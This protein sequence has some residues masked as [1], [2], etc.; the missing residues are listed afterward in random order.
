[1][2]I[3]AQEDLIT[4]VGDSLVG[5]IVN[6]ESVREVYGNV[7]LKQ[8][9]VT[10]TCN[11]A[12][13][14][15]ARNDAELIG[16]VIAVQENTTIKTE[17]GFYY[18][19]EKSTI[20]ETGVSL[21]DG[22]VIL[23]AVVGEYFFNEDRAFFHKD[24]VLYDT[25]TTLTAD[26]LTYFKSE[27]RT[28]ATGNVRIIDASNIIDSDTLEHFRNTRITFASH[29]VKISNNENN[30]VIYGD[31]LEDYAEKNFT[32][33]DKNPLLIQV[34]TTYNP[35]DS[36]N[37]F[38]LDTLVIQSLVM[39][40][41]RDITNLFYAK[42]S[43][44]IV[45]GDFA[46]TND[47]TI[48]YRDI[49]K[50][51]TSKHPRSLKQPVLWQAN[52]QLTGD[53]VT[54]YLREKQISLMDVDRNAFILSQHDI[55]RDRFDQTSGDRVSIHFKEKT[56]D[57][58]EI[59]G[60]V[61]SIYYL[62]E[63]NEPNGLTKSTSRNAIIKFEDKTVSEVRLYGSPSSE[64]YPEGQVAGKELSFTLPKYV[65]YPD[66]PVKEKLIPEWIYEN[67]G[68]IKLLNQIGIQ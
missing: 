66:R 43:V 7:I 50:I 62:Y 49:D 41:Y 8:G 42:D 14:F 20:S 15:I 38:T 3:F 12:I 13:Q 39:E 56:I 51:I 4:V 19:N 25:A 45:R 63:N 23:K 22:K 1:M 53:S 31:H 32:L 11:Q 5:K 48:Y 24:V 26:S 64:Y 10:V 34:D 52:S 35:T 30:I 27:D 18:G 40:A 36:V 57:Y 55:Y 28:V 29:R 2:N 33:I 68:K 17:R 21:D 54:I 9:K 58:T 16:N 47:L 6:G 60:S 44:K 67:Q 59:F 37:S 46:S 65:F 61:Y